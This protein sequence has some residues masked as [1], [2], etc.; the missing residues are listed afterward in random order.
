MYK[1]TKKTI[2]RVYDE[3]LSG[4]S[5]NIGILSYEHTIEGGFTSWVFDDGNEA[6]GMEFLNMFFGKAY[7]IALENAKTEGEAKAQAK[8]LAKSKGYSI[9]RASVAKSKSKSKSKT[10]VKAQRDAKAQA[11]VQRDVYTKAI[12]KALSDGSKAMAEARERAEA[13]EATTD[14]NV[15]AYASTLKEVMRLMGIINCRHNIV[16][17]FRDVVFTEGEQE[18]SARALNAMFSALYEAEA[19]EEQEEQSESDA[20]IAW[21]LS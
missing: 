16:D 19:T 17:G 12:G 5:E 9:T 1:I 13:L 2:K 3:V 20:F 4:M 7:A 6:V 21:A 8:E 18:F 10:E 14:I 15:E 11:K